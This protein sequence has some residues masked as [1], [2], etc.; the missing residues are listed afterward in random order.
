MF[1]KSAL[2]AAML[3]AALPALAEGITISDAYARVS[4]ASA[5]SGAAFMVIENTTAADDRLLGAASDVAAKVE[6]HTHREDAAGVMQMIQVSEGFAIPAQDTHVLA[7][8]GDHV[9]LMGLNGPLAQG[10]SFKLTLTFEK[11]GEITIDV[12]VDLTRDEG[13]MMQGG[14]MGHGHGHAHGQGA[15]N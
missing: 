11:A 8:G 13:G 15:S 14:M 9:M 1:L 7:R 10:D 6:L 5:K 4:G 2:A 3:C 12:P